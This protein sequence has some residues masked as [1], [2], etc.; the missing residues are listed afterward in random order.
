MTRLNWL[1]IMINSICLAISRKRIV[2]RIT[3]EADFQHTKILLLP[4]L[5]QRK[6]KKKRNNLCV[7]L[8]KESSFKFIYLFMI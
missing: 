5:S 4:I 1:V 3:F 7:V 8:W 6:K 2:P